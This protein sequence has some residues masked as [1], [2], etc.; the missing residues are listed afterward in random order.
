MQLLEPVF[1][2]KYCGERAHIEMCKQVREQMIEAIEQ[3]ENIEP[4]AD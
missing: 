2:E 1:P 4:H 3:M